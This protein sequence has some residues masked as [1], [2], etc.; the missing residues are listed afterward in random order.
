MQLGCI[1]L[2]VALDIA[3]YREVVSSTQAQLRHQGCTL[4]LHIIMYE[5]CLLHPQA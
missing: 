2:V 4:I 3:L 1:S 5:E